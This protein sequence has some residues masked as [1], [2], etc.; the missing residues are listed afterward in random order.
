MRSEK[1]LAENM[2]RFGT[3]NLGQAVAV[4]RRI[5]EAAGDEASAITITSEQLTLL[6]EVFTK[7]MAMKNADN[8]LRNVPVK[9]N[10]KPLYVLA[11]AAMN[12]SIGGFFQSLLS[13]RAAG[14]DTVIKNALNGADKDSMKFT[15]DIAE[16]KLS[17][18]ADGTIS[19]TK[20][21]G[22]SVGEFLSYLNTYN[23]ASIFNNKNWSTGGSE[24]YAIDAEN[25]LD[26]NGKQS[27]A[28]TMTTSNTVYLYRLKGAIA[29]AGFS[30]TFVPQPGKYQSVPVNIDGINVA[31]NIDSVVS[32]IVN[33]FLKNPLLKGWTI[34]SIINQTG[35]NGNQSLANYNENLE[36]FKTDTGLT[37]ADLKIPNDQSEIS[38]D[39]DMLKPEFIWPTATTQQT[40][41]LKFLGSKGGP[42]NSSYSHYGGLGPI[43]V[44]RAANIEAA[45]KAIPE[46]A[47]VTIQTKPWVSG[48]DNPNIGPAGTIFFSI[49]GPNG[50]TELTSDLITQIA[51]QKQT[52]AVIERL[53]SDNDVLTMFSKFNQSD[54]ELPSSK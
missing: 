47:N 8:T 39:N 4:I 9:D 35:V 20:Y 3:K 42:A 12:G 28:G 49:K 52:A 29:V 34:S 44:K 30:S 46:F 40:I 18:S 16:I 23:L 54:Q 36:S 17:T 33:D 11:A 45:L 24:Q 7:S 27:L 14:K 6:N 19:I 25:I 15:V 37:D 2:L 10:L 1:I 43:A 38:D 31:A 48:T 26:A 32:V 50:E 41:G 21:A 51:A 13:K 53:V 22:G 5:I